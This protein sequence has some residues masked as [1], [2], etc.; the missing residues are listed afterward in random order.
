[1]GIPLAFAGFAPADE[2]AL[3]GQLHPIEGLFRRRFGLWAARCVGCEASGGA[4]AEKHRML[5]LLPL[6]SVGGR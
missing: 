1:M 3:L 5:S 6:V 2:L 4:L